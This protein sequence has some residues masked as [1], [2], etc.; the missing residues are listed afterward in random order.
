MVD[1]ETVGGA[2]VGRGV[3]VE[4]ALA[5]LDEAT[6]GIE[7]E[8]AARVKVQ[9]GPLED[10]TEHGRTSARSE[11]TGRVVRR[12]ILDEEGRRTLQM[13]VEDTTAR[14]EGA[15]GGAETGAEGGRTGEGQAVDDGVDGKG[16]GRR[17]A[18]VLGIGPGAD[19]GYAARGHVEL[20]GRQGA[21]VVTETHG[22]GC[23]TTR[24]DCRASGEG[25]IITRDRAHGPVTGESESGDIG[26]ERDT[27]HRGQRHHVVADGMIGRRD[28]GNRDHVADQEAVS[29]AVSRVIG[30][31]VAADRAIGR[32][33]CSGSLDAVGRDVVRGIQ[34]KIG[35]AVAGRDAAESGEEHRGVSVAAAER[36]DFQEQRLSR[37]RTE[38]DATRA[39]LLGHGGDAFG[40]SAGR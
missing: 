39:E 32:A 35:D 21:P 25:D 9:R 16:L 7:T 12:T 33:V 23:R 34:A 4:H 30:E 31:D 8:G 15:E 26:P 40:H 3:E 36:T 27:Y 5:T 28:A 6:G 11:R 2:E 38:F 24:G 17:D 37:I 20:V 29:L 18:G 14:T 10:V 13:Q 19:A 1:R 22:D